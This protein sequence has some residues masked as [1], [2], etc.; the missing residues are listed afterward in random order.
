MTIEHHRR[1]ITYETVV[2]PRGSLLGAATGGPRTTEIRLIPPDDV[3][4]IGSYGEYPVSREEINFNSTCQ[5]NG[6]TWYP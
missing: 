2:R 1:I 3:E 5:K 6:I 4:I